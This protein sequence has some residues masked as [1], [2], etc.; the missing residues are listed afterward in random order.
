MTIL[1][2]NANAFYAASKEIVSLVGDL[3]TAAFL[4]QIHAWTENERSGRVFEGTRWIHRSYKAW[5]QE[6]FPHLSISQIRRHIGKLRTLGVIKLEQ[7]TKHHD[8]KNCYWYAVDYEALKNLLLHK[9]CLE[10]SSTAAVVSGEAPVKNDTP[11]EKSSKLSIYKKNLLKKL[12]KENNNTEGAA[13]SFLNLEEE[14]EL[15]QPEGEAAEVQEEGSCTEDALLVESVS[16]NNGVKDS[17]DRE[18]LDACARRDNKTNSISVELEHKINWVTCVAFVESNKNL[19]AQLDK[20]TE[21]DVKKAAYCYLARIE[22]GKEIANPQGWIV[23]CLRHRY[24]VRPISEAEKQRTESNIKETC[25]RFAI[26]P[27]EEWW[28]NFFEEYWEA[29]AVEALLDF[30]EVAVA[31]EERWTKVEM[32]AYEN[33]C[34]VGLLLVKK[35][36]SVQVCVLNAEGDREM[37]PWRQFRQQFFGEV[38]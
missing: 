12:S 35:D 31:G 34:R 27:S 3:T 25:L 32:V 29:I 33:Y 17:L 2:L 10:T 1:T 11:L 23:D 18:R 19:E 37:M 7:W 38:S 13:A 9:S 22:E 4:Q 24:W 14:K 30:D 5:Q 15:S 36:K 8:D 16:L 28:G 26:R 6:D 21:E 20:Y